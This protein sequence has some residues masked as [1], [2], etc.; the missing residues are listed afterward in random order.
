MNR[1]IPQPPL[2][3]FVDF[4]WFYETYA[5]PHGKELML[6]SGTME[7]VFD[8]RFHAAVTV[9]AHSESSIL[10]TSEP[11]SVLGVH[12]KPGGAF[13]FFKPPAHDLHNLEVPLEVLWGRS[14]DDLRDRLMETQ[15]LERRFAI[16]ESAFIGQAARTVERHPAV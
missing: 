16:L 4:F 2:S 9:G 6:P 14:G 3:D 8:L 12:F 10:D 15:S 11:T 5:P 7:L 13:P 1:Y